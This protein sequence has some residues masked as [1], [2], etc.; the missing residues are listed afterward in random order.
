MFCLARASVRLDPGLEVHLLPLVREALVFDD[1]IQPAISER[2]Y[3]LSCSPSSYDAS[4]N[5]GRRSCD[6]IQEGVRWPY[7]W[8]FRRS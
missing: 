1:S 8:C 4:H 5:R 2:R 6:R 3:E 7:R